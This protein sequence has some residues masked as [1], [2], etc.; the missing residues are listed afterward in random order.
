MYL[1]LR[2]GSGGGAHFLRLAEPLSRLDGHVR[3]LWEGLAAVSVL[4]VLGAAIVSYFLARRHA[5]PLLELT[6]LAGAFARG[7]FAQ[8]SLLQGKGEMATL[9]RALNEMADSLSGLVARV[10]RDKEELQTIMAR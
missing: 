8:R 3:V 7:D 5:H 10:A 1:A 9:A 2:V 6:R 4:A